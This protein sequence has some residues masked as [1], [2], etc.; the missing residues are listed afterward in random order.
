MSLRSLSR[1]VTADGEYTISI[2]FSGINY[3]C[4][5]PKNDDKTNKNA[6]CNVDKED[7]KNKSHADVKELIRND[8]LSNYYPTKYSNKTLKSILEYLKNEKYPEGIEEMRRKKNEIIDK[9]ESTK[10]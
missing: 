5:I 8:N 3:D 1:I 2:L 7:L 6:E 4:L 10:N 9:N